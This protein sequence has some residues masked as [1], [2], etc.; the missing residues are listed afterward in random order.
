MITGNLKIPNKDDPS[1]TSE[2]IKFLIDK[3][4]FM[5]KDF[6]Y[7]S[8]WKK[9]CKGYSFLRSLSECADI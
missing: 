5:S 6:D 3:F 4:H 1:E 7:S 8:L 9:H 2:Q